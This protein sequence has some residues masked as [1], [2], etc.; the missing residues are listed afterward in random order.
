MKNDN[1]FHFFLSSYFYQMKNFKIF[2]IEFRCKQIFNFAPKN[3]GIS[4]KQILSSDPLF[5]HALKKIHN[6]VLNFTTRLLHSKFV[7]SLLSL[8]DQPYS[9][10]AEKTEKLSIRRSTWKIIQSP[11]HVAA[12]DD[13]P[14]IWNHLSTS[15]HSRNAP[16]FAKLHFKQH[17]HCKL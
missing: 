9:Y 6:I 17:S 3:S 15:S 2:S 16:Q 7:T 10:V 5:A 14:S 1:F 8:S 13:M 11:W 4:T 12:L